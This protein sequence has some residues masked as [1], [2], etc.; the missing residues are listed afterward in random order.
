VICARERSLN[1]EIVTKFEV[2][3]TL[4]GSGSST[5]TVIGWRVRSYPI[6]PP[7]LQW[8]LPL[9]I[10]ESVIVGNGPGNKHS[11]DM[12]A[13]HLWIEDLYASRRYTLLR[14]GRVAYK[15]RVD[16]FQWEPE[17][18]DAIGNRPQGTL[19]VQAVSAS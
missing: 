15:V 16:N 14:I 12:E 11:F 10:K 7:V 1:G 17:S 3:I 19:I 9:T 13:M 4:L 5:P 6:P 18:W 2:K 8:Y